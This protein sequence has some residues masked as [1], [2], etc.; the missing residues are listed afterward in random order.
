MNDKMSVLRIPIDSIVTEGQLIRA[1][2]DDDH[3]I[4]LSNSISKVGLLQPIVVRLLLKGKHQL[5]AGAH[6]LA[7]CKR[8]KWSHIPAVIKTSDSDEPVRGIA[9]IENIIR[10]NMSLEE[11]CEAVRILTENQSMSVS[12]ICQLLGRGREWV[13]K[14]LAAPGLPENIRQ[15]LFDGLITMNVAEEISGLDDEGA[16]GY[17]LNEAIYAKRSLF[18][19]RT[20]V[21]TFKIT[22]SVTQA[23]EEGIKKADELQKEKAPKKA[24]DYGEEVTPMHEM[25]VL[26]ICRSCHNE[27]MAIRDLAKHVHTEGEVKYETDGQGRDGQDNP[28]VGSTG[29]VNSSDRHEGRVPTDNSTEA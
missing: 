28:G 1:G 4:E 10:K 11:E 20:M 16:R 9:F 29:L 6:R 23:V 18:E 27:I 2:I 21:E 13:V 19:I 12:Q 26:W 17:I 3:V 15:A 22:P 25:L 8:L 14:R 7:A 24:C 5:L